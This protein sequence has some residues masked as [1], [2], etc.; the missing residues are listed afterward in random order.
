MFRLLES[1]E[2]S[3]RRNCEDK[4]IVAMMCIG[5]KA[6]RVVLPCFYC[7][8]DNFRNGLYSVG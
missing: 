6:G 2:Q 3:K 5:K 7:L 4:N 8:T 1:V